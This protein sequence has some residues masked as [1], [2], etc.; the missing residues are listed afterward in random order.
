MEVTNLNLITFLIFIFFISFIFFSLFKF[1]LTEKNININFYLLK[2]WKYFYIKYIFLFISFLLVLV[3]IFWIKYWEKE[4]KNDS[5]GVDITFVLDVSKSMN[6]ADIKGPDYIYT[7]LDIAKNAISKFVTEHKS[8]RFWLIIFAWE[9]IST[10]PVTMDH[11]IFLT[12]LKNVDYRN[13]TKQGSDFTKAISLWIDRFSDSTDRSKALIFISDW[14]D[15]D[16]KIETDKIEDISKQIKWINYFVVWVWTEEG[17]N[18]ITWKDVFWRLAYQ[19][20][21]GEYVVSKLNRNNLHDVSDAL[22]WEYLEVSEVNDILKLNKYINS[23]EKKILVSDVNGEKA[24]AGRVLTIIS[25][26]FF[27]LFLFLYIKPHINHKNQ[28]SP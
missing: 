26:I 24:D 12:F 21:N 2:S 13:L 6:V 20:Y 8:D 5:L 15:L 27:I 9:A 10:I 19:K 11:D 17:G 23:I 3:S 14:W 16:Y 1:Y 25:F 7:R 18:I 28:T 22:N 4:V